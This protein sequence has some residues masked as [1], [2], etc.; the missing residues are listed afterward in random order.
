VKSDY[1][2][3]RDF[4]GLLRYPEAPRLKDEDCQM[5]RFHNSDGAGLANAK[6][7]RDNNKRRSSTDAAALQRLLIWDE[8]LLFQL[9]DVLGNKDGFVR[10]RRR[11]TKA[12]RELLD[13][14]CGIKALSQSLVYFWGYQNARNTPAGRKAAR[15]PSREKVRKVRK[16]WNGGLTELQSK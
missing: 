10:D 13:K 4:D 16:A 1:F 7:Q 6:P 11:F 8:S 15:F 9:H 3:T 14:G 5:E 12:F 2:L